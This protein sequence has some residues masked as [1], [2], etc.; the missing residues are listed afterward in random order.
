[1]SCDP[2]GG[3]WR[4]AGWTNRCTNHIAPIQT[5][6]SI[7]LMRRDERRL[8]G[9]GSRPGGFVIP[10]ASATMTAQSRRWPA[11]WRSSSG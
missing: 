10:C 7:F 5:G 11:G 4:D 2:G 3:Q 1:M 6:R 8:T 9:C